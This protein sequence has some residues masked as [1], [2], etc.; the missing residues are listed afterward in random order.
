MG[1][2]VRLCKFF[3]QVYG[4]SV[5]AAVMMVHQASRTLVQRVNSRV[6]SFCNKKALCTLSEKKKKM[7]ISE[8]T[9]SKS[10][11]FLS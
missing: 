7:D 6:F 5:A 10:K 4:P 8:T 1:L 2:E 3:F 9:Q 11:V